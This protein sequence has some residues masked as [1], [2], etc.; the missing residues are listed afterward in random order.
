MTYHAWLRLWKKL[1]KLGA[2]LSQQRYVLFSETKIS[3]LIIDRDQCV[4]LEV[5]EGV[6]P[7]TH[8]IQKASHMKIV[9]R[10][11]CSDSLV[12]KREE[13]NSWALLMEDFYYAGRKFPIG[14]RKELRTMK[15]CEKL[16]Q[17]GV[18][19]SPAKKRGRKQGWRWLAKDHW[20][21]K[22]KQFCRVPTAFTE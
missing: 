9:L 2:L 18:V 15:N 1:K 6:I 19:Q 21:G 11:V 17:V 3:K 8:A 13:K 20:K 7:R 4:S 16:V 10:S 12:T 5:S 14:E 22:D